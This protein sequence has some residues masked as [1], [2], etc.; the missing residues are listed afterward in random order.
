MLSLVLVV[1][2]PRIAF[3]DTVCFDLE[4]GN[5]DLDSDEDEV[6]ED[7]TCKICAWQTTVEGPYECKT[8]IK[9][10]G[11]AAADLPD[12]DKSC[13]DFKS[14]ILTK[15]SP[16][17]VSTDCEDAMWIDRLQVNG[18]GDSS[19]SEDDSEEWHDWQVLR[20]AN[21]NDGWCLSKDRNDHLG[22]NH[23]D[24]DQHVPANKCYHELK[25]N[26]DGSVDGTYDTS[27][28]QLCRREK[29][30]DCKQGCES[31]WKHVSTSDHGCCSGF[32]SCGGNRKTC[33]IDEPCRRRVETS[34]AE[35]VSVRVLGSSED[36]RKWVQLRA[37]RNSPPANVVAEQRVSVAAEQLAERLSTASTWSTEATAPAKSTESVKDE[38]KSAISMLEKLL[39]EIDA[40][41]GN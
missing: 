13:I 9:N 20:G 40:G 30:M 8:G 33:E 18:D 39:E 24:Y 34:D 5:I 27:Q 16:V 38:V 37:P 12:N 1:F 35:S 15:G 21:N 25:F 32:L 19:D 36:G 29:K 11:T 41:A 7:T 23:D 2:A 28:G 14:G 3:G 26:S 31:G 17:Y 6:H 4:A 22:W 10:S